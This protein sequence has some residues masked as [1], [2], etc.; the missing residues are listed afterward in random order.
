VNRSST[1]SLARAGLLIVLA[2][3]GGYLLLY[4][5]RWEWQRA[6][7]A[8]IFFLAALIVLSTL[9]ILRRLD[10]VARASARQAPPAPLAARAPASGS[11]AEADSFS[12]LAPR[13]TYGV[14]IPILLGFGVVVGLL[15]VAV[16]HLASFIG[17]GTGRPDQVPTEG[18]DART[19]T[20]LRSGAVALVA[21]AV[22]AAAVVVGLRSLT[23][24][25]PD[26]PQPGQ[27]ELTVTLQERRIDAEVGPTTRTILDHC[28]AA[29]GS[30]ITSATVRVI[31]DRQARILLT[32]RLDD[33]AQ[34]RLDGCLQD[35]V[36]DRRLLAIVASTDR[37]R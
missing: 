4:L 2:A 9:L 26:P 8:G 1:A 7:V 31:D 29:T 34:R 14:F 13:D 21:L 3:T 6:I 18:Q 23:M 15:A 33:A 16:E 32:P 19:A 22:V 12:W 20:G 37:G 17:G 24:Y 25:A 30:P 35:L 11:G 36:L 28:I 10:A 5:Y 27:R